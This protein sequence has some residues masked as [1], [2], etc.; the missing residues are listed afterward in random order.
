MGYASI[1][2]FGDRRA[3]IR[4]GIVSSVIANVN[5][6]PKKQSEPFTPLD[7]MPFF[8]YRPPPAPVTDAQT[9]SK[10]LRAAFTQFPR[11]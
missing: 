10:R 11:A 5:R 8:Q 4:S 7:F 2:P 1:A 6:D 9:L 3:D